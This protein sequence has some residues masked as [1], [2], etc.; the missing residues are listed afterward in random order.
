MHN[1]ASSNLFNAIADGEIETETPSLFQIIFVTVFI[2]NS[3]REMKLIDIVSSLLQ[4]LISLG[5]RFYLY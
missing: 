3:S 4:D 2:G 1:H 5:M